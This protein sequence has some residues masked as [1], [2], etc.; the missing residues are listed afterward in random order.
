LFCE[1]AQ[2]F[3]RLRL[4]GCERLRLPTLHRPVQFLGAL[5]CACSFYAHLC[6]EA[7]PFLSIFHR[8]V[9]LLFFLPF[10]QAHWSNP[11]FFFHTLGDFGLALLLSEFV[12]SLVVPLPASTVPHIHPDVSLAARVCRPFQIIPAV[13]IACAR[14]FC[15]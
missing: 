9:V 14:S 6:S 11:P 5:E 3:R 8:P 13:S 12:F 2:P 1:S 15:H 7:L 10:A 4:W